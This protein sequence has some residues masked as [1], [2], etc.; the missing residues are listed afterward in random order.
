M[1]HFC[2]QENSLSIANQRHN[3]YEIERLHWTHILSSLIVSGQQLIKLWA[4][5]RRMITQ[6]LV[7]T[8]EFVLLG[9]ATVLLV[10]AVKNQHDLTRQQKPS[11]IA[12]NAPMLTS[13]PV[14]LLDHNKFPANP[15][16]P[17]TTQ[18]L[19]RCLPHKPMTP[20]QPNHWLINK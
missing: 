5:K 17:L 7:T 3:T 15:Q 10:A 19:L 2:P 13:A 16:P 14:E 1:T 18:P 8:K 20:A 9:F 6:P 11:A 4:V 12:D